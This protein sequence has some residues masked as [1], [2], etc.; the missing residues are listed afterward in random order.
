MKAV[1]V[2]ITEVVQGVK[3]SRNKTKTK[4]ALVASVMEWRSKSFTEKTSGAKTNRFFTHCLG[5]KVLI[6]AFADITFF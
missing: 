6:M 4:K 2:Y 5:L 3:S 1:F